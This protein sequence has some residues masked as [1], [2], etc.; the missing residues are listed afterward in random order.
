ML[1]Q[2]GLPD[3]KI[4]ASN[5]LDEYVIRSLNEQ[6]APIDIFGVGT[7]LATGAPDGSLDG[8]Y[9]IAATG[10]EP[11]LK[12][13][14]SLTKTSLPGRKRLVRCLD[15]DGRFAADVIVLEHET[16]T[17][18]RMVH[19]FAPRQV[20]AL[21][22]L[23]PEPLFVTALGNGLRLA[24]AERTSEIAA[25]ARRRLAAL[26]EEHKRFEDPR[27]YKVGTSER[28]AEMRDGLVRRF[29]KKD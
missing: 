22:G 27:P 25:Y 26:P 3:V 9:K 29:R 5:L 16:G 8:V 24:P 11:R 28:L 23:R 15:G 7:R 4:V 20:L 12:L 14:E 2:A 1:D 10:G 19:P 6:G 17:I 18:P 21:E 13:S